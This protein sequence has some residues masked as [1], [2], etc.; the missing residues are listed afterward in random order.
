MNKRRNI[1]RGMNRRR[2]YISKSITVGLV[3]VV[4][5]GGAFFIK[6]SDFNFTEK[7]SSLNIFNKKELGF[8]E[9][10][11]KDLLGKGDDSKTEAKSE[12]KSKDKEVKKEQEVSNVS[13][14]N[15]KVATVKDWGIYS[16]QI[17]A[18]DNEE[19]LKQ[20]QNKLSELKVPF[21]TVEVDKVQ[22]VQT[23]PSFKEEESRKNLET[24]KKIFQMLL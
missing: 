18:I 2:N 15:A 8:K 3:V 20:I 17:A 19:E 24:L 6:K 4:L 21:S 13:N 12:N 7:I 16:I 22:K 11:Y 14:E 23:Y 10:S 9:F 5:A 1:Y